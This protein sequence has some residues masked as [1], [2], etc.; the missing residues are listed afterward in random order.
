MGKNC[1]VVL[2]FANG[3]AIA[4]H[5]KHISHSNCI[6]ILL[7]SKSQLQLEHLD[8]HTTQ[9]AIDEL[10]GIHYEMYV[11]T[12]VLGYKSAASFL[13]STSVQRRDLIEVL[14]GLLILD[15]YGQVLRLLLRDVDKD[16]NK[17]ESKLKG[18]LQ[19]IEYIERRLE[20]LDRIQQRLKK[21][22]EESVASLKA[23]IQVHIAAE[24]PIDE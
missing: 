2:E 15:Q 4:R 18:L 19:M 16:V 5:R 8:A 20:D 6:V 22:A 11:R 1:S 23:A 21:G 17:M 12:V 24:L 9:A 13:N 10:L 3:Y 7:H 14:L